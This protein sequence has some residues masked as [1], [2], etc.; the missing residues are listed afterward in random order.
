MLMN[1][2]D[3]HKYICQFSSDFSWVCWR[4]GSFICS[5]LMATAYV[6]LSALSVQTVAMGALVSSTQSK[7]IRARW[8]EDFILSW[9]C[10]CV[11]YRDRTTIVTMF[12][13]LL[14]VVDLKKINQQNKSFNTCDPDWV[15]VGNIH[16]LSVALC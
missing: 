3:R 6:W 9:L 14:P 8:M 11:Y 13:C 12:P 15:G 1:T 2:N 16:P 5:H 7:V 4:V 10:V